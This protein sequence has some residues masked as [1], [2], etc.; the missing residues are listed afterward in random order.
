VLR[1]TFHFLARNF[2]VCVS[3]R[4]PAVVANVAGRRFGFD[5]SDE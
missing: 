3:S 4:V 2:D 1:I 5:D